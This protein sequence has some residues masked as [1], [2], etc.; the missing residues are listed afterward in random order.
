MGSHISRSAAA[1]PQMRII[2]DSLRQIVRALRVFDR[3]TEKRL[4]LSGAQVFVLE[5]LRD[6]GGISINTLAQR[7]HTHQSSVSVV[8]QKLVDRKLV[9]R[10]A[11]DADARRLQLSLTAAGHRALKS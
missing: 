11:A 7:T 5:N 4:G 1:P 10:A 3:E 2:L 9:A 8:V 6:A